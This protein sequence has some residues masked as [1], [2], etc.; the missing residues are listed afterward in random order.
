MKVLTLDRRSFE[1]SCRRL[2]A[3]VVNSD[4][5]PDLIVG[6]R[7]GGEYV[8][9]GLHVCFPHASLVSV[10]LQRPSTHKKHYLG[11]FLRFFP[12]WIL[13]MMRIVEAR[14]L[15][16]HPKRAC[17]MEPVA[18]PVSLQK[19]GTKRVLLVDDAVDS[20]VTMYR[21]VM[22]LRSENPKI[23]LRTAAITV[24]T[25]DP[26][27]RPDWALYNNGILIRFPWSMDAR[28]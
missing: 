28:K 2:G 21:I 20:G 6:I 12:Q 26:I 1:E 10:S 22:A 9:W 25:D 23:D 7:R 11:S 4:F 8:A 17:D 27:V 3:L 14:W 5:T 13:D 19:L 24:T 18:L 16:R 15:A